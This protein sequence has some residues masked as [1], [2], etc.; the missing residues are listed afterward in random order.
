MMICSIDFLSLVLFFRLCVR[1]CVVVET[2][3]LFVSFGMKKKKKK[4]KRRTKN[5]KNDEKQTKR[6]EKPL[7]KIFGTDEPQLHHSHM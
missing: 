2:Q 4:K 7:K 3:A 6:E 5:K 1:W